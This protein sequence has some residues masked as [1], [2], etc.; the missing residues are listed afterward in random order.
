LLHILIIG[1][2]AAA[3]NIGQHIAKHHL[4]TMTFINRTQARAAALAA[5]CA[6]HALPWSALSEALSQADVVIAAT[7]APHPI[8]TRPVLDEVMRRRP[9]RPLLVIDTGLP[10]N[11]EPGAAVDLLDIDA[12]HER[13]EEGLAQRRAAIPAVQRMVEDEAHTWEHWRAS[14]PMESMLKGLYQRAVL[15]SQEA[16]QHVV[17]LDTLAPAQIERIIFQSF[18]RL[19]H[20]HAGDLRGLPG[21]HDSSAQGFES[22]SGV[23]FPTAYTPGASLLWEEV[24][25]GG[26]GT[27]AAL[28]KAVLVVT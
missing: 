9:Q 13:Q 22:A 12:I 23:R 11:V 14:L 25:Q 3:R 17:A 26:T 6:G 19:L 27:P 15:L 28:A 8:V 2:G 10:R 16:T 1:A 24:S 7:A 5:Y 21:G 20:R 4:G 18:K